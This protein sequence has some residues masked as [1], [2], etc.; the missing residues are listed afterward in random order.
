MSAD[1]LRL[2]AIDPLALAVQWKAK[3]P[4]A[5]RSIVAWARFDVAR[6]FRASTKLYVELLRHPHFAGLLGL[7][8]PIGSP[9]KLPNA[10]TPDLARLVER[11]HPDLAGA[12]RK[13]DARADKWWAA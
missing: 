7:A 10:L 11:E 13:G 3:N 2:P 9:V 4:A 1:Q 8:P 12:F 6:G 5:Y